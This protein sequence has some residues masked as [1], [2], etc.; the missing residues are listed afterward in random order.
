MSFW[1]AFNSLCKSLTCIP[2]VPAHVVD[3]PPPRDP[4]AP[5]R[6]FIATPI[7]T[8]FIEDVAE[9]VWLSMYCC[10]SIQSQVHLTA[11]S[12][13]SSSAVTD[14]ATNWELVDSLILTVLSQQDE[15]T[16]PLLSRF[17]E[18]NLH[19]YVDV[20]F[21]CRSDLPIHR[22]QISRSDYVQLCLGRVLSLSHQW[23]ACLSLSLSLWKVM[24]QASTDVSRLCSF[25]PFLVS[26]VLVSAIP[27]LISLC[28]GPL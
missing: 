12:N 16:S 6:S 14:I 24:L 7:R 5:L 10:S 2:G 17:H 4:L 26:R 3:P 1:S 13:S 18:Q 22:P 11:S 8:T 21:V 25:P 27:I 15:S 19:K 9:F 20:Y 28:K 23:G